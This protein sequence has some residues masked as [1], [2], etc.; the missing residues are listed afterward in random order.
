MSPMCV[1]VLVVSWRACVCVLKFGV[2][3]GQAHVCTNPKEKFT[4]FF[5]KTAIAF[6]SKR[7]PNKEKPTHTHTCT[8]KH[9]IFVQNEINFDFF[10]H[11]YK[12]VSCMDIG[13]FS[14]VNLKLKETKIKKI[15]LK[16]ST[17]PIYANL[18]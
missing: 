17:M 12:V 4:F 11:N 18:Y 3:I 1:F 6:C 10:R 15:G 5:N 9:T 2:R 7:K 16:S 14:F 13:H 8:R